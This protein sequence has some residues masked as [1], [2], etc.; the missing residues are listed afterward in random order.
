MEFVTASA[1]ATA[2]DTCCIAV[3]T[4]VVCVNSNVAVAAAAVAAALAVI[5]FTPEVKPAH[6]AKQYRED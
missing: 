3:G 4:S 2:V 1:V 5:K 6:W